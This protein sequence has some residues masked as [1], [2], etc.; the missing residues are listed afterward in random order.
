[1][2]PACILILY[3]LSSCRDYLHGPLRGGSRTRIALSVFF[4]E[5]FVWLVARLKDVT[6][7]GPHMF[8]VKDVQGDYCNPADN[9]FDH[10]FL[11][12]A[13]AVMSLISYIR[14]NILL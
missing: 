12:V 7:V 6:M 1:M 4:P 2:C 9:G 8:E 14:G 13:L 3:V 5:H 10:V 11:S